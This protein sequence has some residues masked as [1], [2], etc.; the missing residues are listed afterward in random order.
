VNTIGDLAGQTLFDDAILGT[1][2]RVT[3]ADQLTAQFML[4]LHRGT[5]SGDVEIEGQQFTGTPLPAT[6]DPEDTPSV[7]VSAPQ[8]T[9]RLRT[10]IRGPDAGTTVSLDF[11]DAYARDLVLDR[12]LEPAA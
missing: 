5:I 2:M 6:L 9:W 7:E 10:G 12:L 11:A 1:I 4:A 3:G 8:W